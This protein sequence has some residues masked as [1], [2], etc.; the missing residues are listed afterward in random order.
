MTYSVK[1]GAIE[2][3][4]NNIICVNANEEGKLSNDKH[5]LKYDLIGPNKAVTKIEFDQ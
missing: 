1:T 5:I 4:V 3:G 2:H